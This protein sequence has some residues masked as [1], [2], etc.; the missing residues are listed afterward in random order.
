M[1]KQ[2]FLKELGTHRNKLMSIANN[3]TRD[4]F[5][6]EDLVQITFERAI[7]SFD[8]FR[9]EENLIAWLTGILKYRFFDYKRSQKRLK[10][11]KIQYE[12]E[13]I[14]DEHSTL[15][16]SPCHQHMQLIDTFTKDA[17]GKYVDVALT[18]YKYRKYDKTINFDPTR[19]ILLEER[20]KIL[21][22]A[23]AGLT[24]LQK[25]IANMYYLKE[26]TIHEIVK[27][28]NKTDNSIYNHLHHARRKLRQNKK[29]R[30]YMA[31]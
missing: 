14:R 16:D 6:A 28:T 3:L 17:H 18:G 15:D 7:K 21:M 9:N 30:Q 12:H 4:Y 27:L 1:T 19:F 20:D 11:S 23:F 22:D 29:L 25:E 10:N 31:I 26:M 2:E 8:T 13:Y 5:V 24:E